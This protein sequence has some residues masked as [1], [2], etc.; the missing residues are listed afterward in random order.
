MVMAVVLGVCAVVIVRWWTFDP[1]PQLVDLAAT[2]PAPAGMHEVAAPTA[3][4]D[5]PSVCGVVPSCDSQR[6]TVQWAPNEAS[7]DPCAAL[8]DAADDWSAQGFEQ[9]SLDPGV[10]VLACDVR[11]ELHGHPAGAQVLGDRVVFSVRW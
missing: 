10:V 4:G 5:R 9:T 7:V 11:G 1:G 2:L 3:R 8:H 6:I